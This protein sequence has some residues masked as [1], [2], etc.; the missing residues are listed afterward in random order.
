MNT[1]QTISE[2]VRGIAGRHLR[3]PRSSLF[4]V[5]CLTVVCVACGDRFRPV[6]LPIPGPTP[7]PA[8]SQTVAVLSSNGAFDPGGLSRI[9]VSGDSVSSVFATGAAP[10]HAAWL[11][12][13]TK[14]YV[15]NRG[16]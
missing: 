8:A 9:D 12:N 7:N 4:P 3:S 16:E 5:V 10:V 14:I 11:P 2:V 6:A 13:G 15:A 1:F